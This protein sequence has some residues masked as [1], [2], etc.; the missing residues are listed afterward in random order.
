[1]INYNTKWII[2]GILGIRNELCCFTDFKTGPALYILQKTFISALL[3]KGLYVKF[4]IFSTIKVIFKAYFSSLTGKTRQHQNGVLE[5]KQ[6]L[7]HR[8]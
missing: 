3:A 8:I 1:M 2:Y 5:Y 4:L 6:F 7:R